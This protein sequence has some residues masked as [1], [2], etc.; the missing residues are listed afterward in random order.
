MRSLCPGWNGSDWH[1][2]QINANV[3]SELCRCLPRRDFS[4]VQLQL[5][6]ASPST[7]RT[8]TAKTAKTAQIFVNDTIAALDRTVSITLEDPSGQ[9][10]RVTNQEVLGYDMYIMYCVNLM[11][12]VLKHPEMEEF[13]KQ[14]V[15]RTGVVWGQRTRRFVHGMLSSCPE[16]TIPCKNH[17]PFGPLRGKSNKGS[18][19]Y[20]IYT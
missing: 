12:C 17:S 16:W 2:L 19:E 14:T 11:H 5:H 13:S 6:S 20:T 1:L 10:P 4:H 7:T 3:F 18:I 8:K 9:A 15:G